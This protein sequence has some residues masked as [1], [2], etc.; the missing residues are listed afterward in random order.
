MGAAEGGGSGVAGGIGVVGAD[1]VLAAEGLEPG[2]EPGGDAGGG[3]EEGAGRQFRGQQLQGGEGVDGAFDEQGG[4]GRCR[5]VEQP[6]AAAGLARSRRHALESAVARIG[7]GA[8][9]FGAG[10]GA[11]RV[12][13]QE[14]GVAATVGVEQSGV[15]AELQQARV[16]AARRGQVVAHAGPEAVVALGQPQR[17]RRRDR[18][19]RRAGRGRAGG[20]EELDGL[21]EAAAARMHDQVDGPPAA[22]MAFV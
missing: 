1:E 13:A 19:G 18:A 17:T 2:R 14:D 10:G 11:A 6:E 22:A 8:D 4:A 3:G 12:A 16:E 15:V 9:D 5:A 21:L 7:A 20:L